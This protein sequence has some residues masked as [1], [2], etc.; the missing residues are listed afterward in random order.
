[1]THFSGLQT[2]HLLRQKHSRPIFSPHP[3]VNAVVLIS[4][5]MAGYLFSIDNSDRDSPKKSRDK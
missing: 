4:G 5:D 1:L 3:K 2:E